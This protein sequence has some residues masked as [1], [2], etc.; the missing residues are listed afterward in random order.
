MVGFGKMNTISQVEAR[1][2]LTR[3]KNI[4]V[5][6]VRAEH[7]YAN[8]H[9]KDAINIPFEHIAEIVVEQIQ[10]K[11]QKIFV[12]CLNGSKSKSAVSLIRARGFTNVYDIGG[13]STWKYG[14]YVDD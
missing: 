4:I 5:I 6:D 13:I 7:E 8:G 9:I 1:K 11:N 10:D 14:L 3:D 12:N 2:Q